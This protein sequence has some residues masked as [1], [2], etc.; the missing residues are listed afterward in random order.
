[1][2]AESDRIPPAMFEINKNIDSK[3][4]CEILFFDNVIEKQDEEPKYEH[5]L[6]R[7][8]LPYRVGLENDIENNY[9]AYL[10][11]AKEMESNSIPKP[12]IEER[13][14]NVETEVVEVREVIDTLFGG[15]E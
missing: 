4:N 13:V 10:A 15:A 7:L 12:S 2:R 5:E 3:G 8:V 1:M 6:Y 9:Q 14:D 11:A